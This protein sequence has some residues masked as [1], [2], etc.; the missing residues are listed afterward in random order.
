MTRSRTTGWLTRTRAGGMVGRAL[1][2]F[3]RGRYAEAAILFE[4]ACELDPEGKGVRIERLHA[5]LG[6]CYRALG[7]FKEALEYLS[8]A[9]EPYWK[10]RAALKRPN[11]KREFIEFLTAFSDVL[12]RAG[13]VERAEEIAQQ[14][15]E[16]QQRAGVC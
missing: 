7:R 5:S 3:Y 16:Y 11:D 6:C 9:Y 2:H 1:G 12:L 10:Q 13:E 8:R 4:K 14:A 15:R